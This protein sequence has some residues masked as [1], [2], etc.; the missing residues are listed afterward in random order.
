MNDEIIA[1]LQGDRPPGIYRITSHL[2]LAELAAFCE[3][4][5]FKLFLI[6]GDRANNKAAFMHESAQVMNFPD[7]FGANWDAFEDCL[8]DLEWLPANGYVLLYLYPE[9]FAE[10]HPTD[11]SIV[12]SILQSA[13]EEWRK[14]ESPLFV[15]FKTNK[16]TLSEF[17]EL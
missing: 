3:E 10:A 11:W 7:Y 4:R 9:H 17:K 1:T 15:F 2:A 16:L 12:V 6:Q 8:T 14:T 13:V 5:N